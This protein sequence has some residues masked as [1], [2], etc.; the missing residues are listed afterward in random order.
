MYHSQDPAII[1]DCSM[2]QV[3][4]MQDTH[5]LLLSWVALLV[6]H[7]NLLHLG[8]NAVVVHFVHNLLS[9]QQQM[10]IMPLI[11]RAVKVIQQSAG[12]SS[13]KENIAYLCSAVHS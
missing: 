3:R 6:M 2:L 12:S 10:G 8:H 5:V 1:A 9:F 7:P 11:H 4:F 13:Q